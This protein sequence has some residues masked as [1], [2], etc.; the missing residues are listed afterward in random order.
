MISV[1]LKRSWPL[2]GFIEGIVTL[3][4]RGTKRGYTQGIIYGTIKVLGAESRGIEPVLAPRLK[5]ARE[6]SRKEHSRAYRSP[7]VA[8]KEKYDEKNHPLF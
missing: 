1:V 3:P 5:Y 7:Y 4:R 8:N 2:T 6:C